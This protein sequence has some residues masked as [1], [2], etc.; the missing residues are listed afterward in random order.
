M[1]ILPVLRRM[2]EQGI[3]ESA[4]RALNTCS[5]VFRFAVATG[6]ADRDITVDLRG[7]LPPTPTRH[8]AA[9]MTHRFLLRS[10]R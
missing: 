4:H 8:R 10:G 9:V 5:Q 7:A 3:L 2:E 6:R 1:E